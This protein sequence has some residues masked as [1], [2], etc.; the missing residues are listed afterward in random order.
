MRFIDEVKVEVTAGKGGDGFVGWRRE[1]F[2]P[3]GGPNGGDGGNGGAVVFVV[4][5]G[6]NTLLDFSFSPL[7]RA[8]D[9]ESGGTQQL[10]G[11]NGEDV[12]R[13]VPLGT[14]VYFN[15][16]LVADLSVPNARW[17]AARG[18]SGGKGNTHFKSSKNQ[19]PDYAPPGQ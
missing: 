17:I 3:E 9:G 5:T 14:Q 18:G 4:D 2:V 1:K 15:D 16:K 6:L 8:A 12:V 19:A 7:I 11:R 13:P 10:T